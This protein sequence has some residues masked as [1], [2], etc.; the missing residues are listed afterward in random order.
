MEEFRKKCCNAIIDLPDFKVS[1]LCIETWPCCHDVF[2]NGDTIVASG[3]SI[4]EECQ[5]RGIE[6]PHFE[7]YSEALFED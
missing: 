2:V 7:C 4:Y 6:H 1:G 3:K 5:K